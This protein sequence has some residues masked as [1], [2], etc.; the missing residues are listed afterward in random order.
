MIFLKFFQSHDKKKQQKNSGKPRKTK[1]EPQTKHSLKNFGFLSFYTNHF[2]GKKI[3]EKRIFH[4]FS[5]I[6]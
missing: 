4:D 1:H 5:I 2:V 6:F 3:I